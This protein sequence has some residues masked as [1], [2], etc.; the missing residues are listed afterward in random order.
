MISINISELIW[1]VINFFL[2]MYLLNRF[3]FKPVISFMDERQAYIDV[4]HKEEEDAKA[5]IEANNTRIQE[6]KAKCREEAKQLLAQNA[7]EIETRS[8]EAMQE[9]KKQVA[10]YRKDAEA[11]LSERER[12]TAQQL[13]EA[14]PELAQVLTERLLSAE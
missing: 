6:E 13:Y 9:A 7:E 3:L 12:R 11:E 5:E 1:T 4:R 14:T 2:L 10:Q 8:A